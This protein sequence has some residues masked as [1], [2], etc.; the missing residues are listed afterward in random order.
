MI[1]TLTNYFAIVS[2]ISS[3]SISGAYSDNYMCFFSLWRILWLLWHTPQ[4]IRFASNIYSVNKIQHGKPFGS[5]RFK[6]TKMFQQSIDAR[7]AQ[8]TVIIFNISKLFFSF[9]VCQWVQTG[10]VG[11]G[12]QVIGHPL[13]L[14][15]WA[16]LFCLNGRIAMRSYVY[17][18]MWFIY[19]F[20]CIY[21]YLYI[22][23]FAFI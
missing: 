11:Q 23:S 6:Q 4:S 16:Y 1:P 15:S 17:V 12:S 19:I 10:F 13:G 8:D 21:I 3:R 22:Y 14:E 20:M 9:P 2:D 7:L 5:N 18:H